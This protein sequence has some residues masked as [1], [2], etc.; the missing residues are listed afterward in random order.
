MHLSYNSRVFS[1]AWCRGVWRAWRSGRQDLADRA[2][3]SQRDERERAT[4]VESA[5]GG[6]R[7]MLG[8][9]E[10]VWNSRISTTS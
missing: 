6:H 7:G 3:G 10:I 1:Q 2:D 5:E 8:R 9:I 4:V